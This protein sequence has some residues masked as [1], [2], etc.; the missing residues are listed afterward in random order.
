MNCL[1]FINVNVQI[2]ET[3]DIYVYNKVLNY[4]KSE[5]FSQQLLRSGAQSQKT[6][7]SW[8]Y[9]TSIRQKN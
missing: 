4:S 7:R 9:F 5:T 6:L 8:F 2:Q 3:L 1:V